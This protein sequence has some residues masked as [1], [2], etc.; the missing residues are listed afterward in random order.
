MGAA[1]LL[2]L[3]PCNK[4]S[5]A[6]SKYG[7]KRTHVRVE[8][9][10]GLRAGEWTSSAGWQETVDTPITIPACLPQIRANELVRVA[11]L[12]RGQFGNV[13]LA[14]WHGVEVAELGRGQFGSV[15]LARWHGVEVAL[16]ELHGANSPRSREEMLGEACTLAS[17]RHP[18]VIAIYGVIIGQGSPASVLE[19]V[20]GSSL[21]SGLQRL[22][23]AGPV[24][25]RLRAAIALQAARGM[26]YLHSRH[27]VHF[28]LKCDN[29]LADLRDPLRPAV[30]IGDL[31][32]SKQKARRFRAATFMSGNMRGTMPW[33]A[34][35][36]FPVMTSMRDTGVMVYPGLSL[37][38]IFTGVIN[39]TLRPAMPPDAPQPWRE[40]MDA[41]CSSHPGDRP[42]FSDIAATLKTLTAAL[43][44]SEARL[45]AISQSVSQS[46]TP[47]PA[48]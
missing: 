35:E 39:G 33:M 26:E 29:L 47:F 46:M 10:S 34:P 9:G 17:L 12:G 13:W 44:D 41:C 7:T 8:V 4:T 16:K 14:R 45:G 36:L 3:I 48:T 5:R 21:R 25:G 30:K 37:P 15:W 22:A 6:L 27:V 19:Y 11:E 20:E 40:L 23:V 18:C 2:G 24:S 43:A 38:A 31:G 32:L 42:S 28:D 1:C